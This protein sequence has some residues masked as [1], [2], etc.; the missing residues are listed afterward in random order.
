[1]DADTRLNQFV[2]DNLTYAIKGL[3]IGSVLSL[4][5]AKKQRI[6]GYSLGFALGISISKHCAD[7]INSKLK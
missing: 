3:A 2:V 6:I 5:F 4:F 7:I 1:L